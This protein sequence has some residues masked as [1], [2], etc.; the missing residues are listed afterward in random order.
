MGEPGLAVATK[1]HSPAL[2]GYQEPE[3][4]KEI[5]KPISI[6]VLQRLVES[7]NG[8]VSMES[9]NILKEVYETIIEKP[10]RK[11]GYADW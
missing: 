4:L 7:S 11:P 2:E 1:F 6:G 3:I 5:D 9:D 10:R 8:I